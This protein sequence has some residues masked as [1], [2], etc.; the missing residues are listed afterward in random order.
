[1][2]TPIALVFVLPVVLAGCTSSPRS[3]EIV[4]HTTAAVT[5]TVASDVKGAVLGISDGLRH[6]AMH[7]AVDVNSASRQTL[8]TLPGVTKELAERIV[9]D[10]PYKH[11]DDLVHR[12]IMP[13]AVYNKNAS[14]LVAR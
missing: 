10:R 2:K 11:P 12:H 5:R 1:M 6:D 9:R 4:R 8:E 7:D 3:Q 14:R 13:K